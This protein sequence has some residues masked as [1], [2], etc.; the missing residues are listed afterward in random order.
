MEDRKLSVLEVLKINMNIL[1][2]MRIPIGE[3]QIWDGI[4]GVMQNE[5]ACIEPKP[6]MLHSATAAS[7][8]PAMMMSALPSLSRLK[9]SL[10]AT[11]DEAHAATVQ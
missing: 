5:R 3:R 4:Q 7:E 8:P 1:E 11:A 6:P 2:N 10:M 9:A